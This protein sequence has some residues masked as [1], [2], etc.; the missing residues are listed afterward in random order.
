M[1]PYREALGSRLLL[2]RKSGL[3]VLRACLHRRWHYA[4][5]EAGLA[6]TSGSLG[7]VITGSMTTEGLRA[8]LRRLPEG[9][10]EL[11]CH[12]GYNDRELDGVRTRLRASREIEMSALLALTRDELRDE[13][14][15][16]LVSFAALAPQAGEATGTH[17]RSAPPQQVKSSLSPE[18]RRAGGPAAADPSGGER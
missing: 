8:M 1:I 5:R 4:V 15:A 6:T 17:G 2:L 3:A 11:V 13:F 9:T 10:W 12:P 16:E 18:S 7:M 14:G